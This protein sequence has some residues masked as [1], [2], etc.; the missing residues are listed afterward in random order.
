VCPVSTERRNRNWSKALPPA[1]TPVSPSEF[2]HLAATLGLSPEQY[3]GSTVLKEWARKNMNSKY[4]PIELLTAW[5][6]TVDP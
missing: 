4:V 2:E 6:F 5:R 1:I 3:E